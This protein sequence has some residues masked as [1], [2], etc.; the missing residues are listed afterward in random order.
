MTKTTVIFLIIAAGVFCYLN[1]LDGDFVWDDRSYVNNNPAIRSLRALRTFFTEPQTLAAGTLAFEN[2]RPFVTLSYAIDYSLWGLS[3]FGYH[4][5]NILLHIANAIL[6]FFLVE[7]IVRKRIPAAFAA[8]LFA[9]HPIQTEA[10]TWISGRSNVLFLFFYL[11]AFLF[12]MGWRARENT[13]PYYLFSLFGFAG[14]LLSKETA[15]TFPLLIVLYDVIFIRRKKNSGKAYIAWLPF[16]ALLAAYLLGRYAILGKVAQCSYWSGNPFIN[17]LTVP[18]IFL[19]YARFMLFPIRLCSD[20]LISVV[21]SP[22]NPYFL[23]GVGFLILSL[24]AFV[25]F[26]KRNGAVAFFIAWFFI[27]LLPVSNIIPIKILVAERFLYLP[28]IAVTTLTGIFLSHILKNQVLLFASFAVIIVGASFA[29]IE[30]NRD[31]KTELALFE[32]DIKKE[33][34]NA[35]LHNNLGRAHYESGNDKFPE[36]EKEYKK[37]IRLDKNFVPAYINLS[38]LYFETMKPGEALA[39]AEKGLLIEPQRPEL[40]NTIALVRAL[41]GERERARVLFEKIIRKNPDYFTAYLNLGQLL[42]LEE[43]Y[44]DAVGVY[45]RMLKRAKT[46]KHKSMAWFRIATACEGAGDYEAARRA[47][48][49]ILENFSAESEAYTITQDKIKNSIILK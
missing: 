23:G 47:Y 49:Y 21:P 28:G 11:G 17:L 42:M 5:T 13:Q 44:K 10:V 22:A 9:V 30:R 19:T 39:V 25:N 24:V 31:W 16:F 45:E 38:K 43:K 41:G 14:A 32:N 35:R 18:K 34:L 40:S 12:Y 1:S 33:P 4:L 37:A 27:T 7:K 6:V 48:R 20:H 26:V 29:T 46:E 3:T 2:Y 36:A 15:A 8:L